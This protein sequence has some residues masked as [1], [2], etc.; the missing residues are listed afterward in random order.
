MEWRASGPIALRDA[1]SALDKQPHGSATAGMLASE[2][3]WCSRV[4][5]GFACKSIDACPKAAQH[6]DAFRGACARCDVQ[7][8]F[9]SLPA[10]RIHE[11]RRPLE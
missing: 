7:W 6:A 3:Q 9:A 5:V 10:D 8:L 4:A 1:R 2:V 11:V